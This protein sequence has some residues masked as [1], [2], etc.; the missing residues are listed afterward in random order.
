MTNGIRLSTGNERKT[1]VKKM[2]NNIAPRYDLLN[3]LLSFG[4]DILWRKKAINQLENKNDKSRILDLA[5]GT[6]DFA[7]EAAR[8]TGSSLVGVDIAL[9]MIKHGKNKRKDETVLFLNSDAE[10]LPFQNNTFD[11]VI[12]AF[13]I[14][15]MGSISKALEEMFRVLKPRSEAIIL[16]FSIP[17]YEPFKSLYLFYFNNVLPWIGKKISRDSEAYHY[18]PASVD[19]FPVISKFKNQ[20]A[21]RG[22]RSIRLIRLLFGVAVIYIG[23]K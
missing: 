2:F 23:K 4:M 22:F 13:G 11:A 1:Y 5:S 10:N 7:Y 3:H 21:Q 19:A 18:L 6:G 12:I 20:M 17:R 9:E 8:K 16:E 15:N 14:R